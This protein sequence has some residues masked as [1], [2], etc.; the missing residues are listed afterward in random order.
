MNFSLDRVLS[1]ASKLKLSGGLVG[2]VCH[3]LIVACA[4]IAVVGAFSGNAWIMAVAIL[5]IFLF[6][7]PL[8]WRIISFAEKHPGVAILDGAHFLKHEQMRLASKDS[9]DIVVLPATQVADPFPL[10]EPTPALQIAVDSSDQPAPSLPN[11]RGE[12]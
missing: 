6:A 7:Y 12:H 9:P 4:C 3:V 2:R 5:A 10:P 1:S 11:E 8:L